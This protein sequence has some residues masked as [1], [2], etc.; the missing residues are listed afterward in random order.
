MVTNVFRSSSTFRVVTMHYNEMKHPVHHIIVLLSRTRRAALLP[1]LVQ[2]CG[3]LHR[4]M[5]RQTVSM[6][7]SYTCTYMHV[8]HVDVQI[9]PPP[10]SLLPPPFSSSPSSPFFY[11]SNFLFTPAAPPKLFTPAFCFTPAAFYPSSFCLTPAA[12]PL[13]HP[14]AA[15]CSSLFFYPS[16]LLYY[17]SSHFFYPSSFFHCLSSALFYPSSLFITPAALLFYPKVGE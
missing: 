10:S 17:C 1:A 12:P 4:R 6:S 3:S 5:D 9:L 7:S 11:P 16:S 14:L 15:F 2:S 13:P 8:E